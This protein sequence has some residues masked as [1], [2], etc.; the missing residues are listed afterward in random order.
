MVIRMKTNDY[1]KFMTQQF[2]SYIDSPAE[3]K[4]QRKQEKKEE[5]ELFTS[6]WFGILP[7]ALKMLV[8]KEKKDGN[9]KNI[10]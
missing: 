3:E 4:K 1:V 8:D 9:K 5:K 2:V 10:G 6:K 7:L